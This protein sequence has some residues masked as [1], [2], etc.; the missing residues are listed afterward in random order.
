M[1]QTL[2]CGSVSTKLQRIAQLAKEHP[3]RS[4][5]AISHV[6]DIEL[7]KEAYQR[8]RK[9][10][11]VG[12][13]EQTA[14]Q[15]TQNLESNLASL[16]QRFK[17][18]SYRAP[19]VRRVYIPKGEGDAVRA[20][21]IPT[22][23]DK[24]LQQAVSMVVQA[25][26]EQDFEDCSYGFRPKRSAHQALE[27]LWNNLMEMHG[28]WVVEVD[29]KDYFGSLEHKQL[30]GFLD[31]RVKDGVIRRVIDKWLKAG[32]ME[33]GYIRYSDAG[34]PQGGVISP[35]LSNVYLHEV[36]DSW[37]ERQVKPEL[38]GHGAL[39]RYADDFVM[40]F[41]HRSDAERVMQVLPK[42]CGKYGLTIHPDKTRL[43]CF[44][45]PALVRN[46]ANRKG[47]GSFN[48][49][50][51]THYWC[52]TRKGKWAVRKK[53]SSKRLTRAIAKV[54]AFCRRNR[55][56]P[57]REQQQALNR[58]LQGHYNYYGITW[59][60]Q[61]LSELYYNVKAC[62]RKWLN[63][64]GARR[65]MNWER[66]EQLLRHYPLLKPRIVHGVSHA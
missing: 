9:N 50:G 28:G 15:Y 21:G 41:E 60:Y 8:T 61:A 18:G 39:I 64:R 40:I 56:E 20:I 63:R 25:I 35:V 12:V 5:T 58:K 49:L 22:F 23:E 36:L 44:K 29:L 47:P 16:L 42:R 33:Q 17:D 4:F 32:V 7:L 10:A 43:V 14:Q 37:F 26:Y 31:R 13:D 3:E 1:Q 11:A 38:T 62:W 52:R 19:P 48:F 54:Q 57:I 53:T 30:R 59:N 65:P 55:H 34:T 27:T 45:R 46:D 24:V 6:I 2:S 66:F 51:F